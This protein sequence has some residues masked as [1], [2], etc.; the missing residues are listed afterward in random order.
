[1]RPTL[2]AQRPVHACPVA[3]HTLDR[4]M[5]RSSLL[6][7]R[8]IGAGLGL[9]AAAASCVFIIWRLIESAQ[10]A[11][12]TLQLFNA[13]EQPVQVSAVQLSGQDVGTRGL[14]LSGKS[15]GGAEGAWSSTAVTLEPGRLVTVTLG[16]VG[17]RGM[18]TCTLEPRPPGL[19]A[20][21]ARFKGTA[22]LFCDYD[23]RVPGDA[24]R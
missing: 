15:P 3:A 14:T 9:L 10:P 24:K 20:V 4:T 17:L 2:D 11:P 19:C 22:E 13:T 18:A 7:P 1:M 21:R 16:A 5:A 6:T 23:C 12:T 8:A